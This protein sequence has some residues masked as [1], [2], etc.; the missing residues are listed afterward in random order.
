MYHEND[1]I[2]DISILNQPNQ[3]K[4]LAISNINAEHVFSVINVIQFSYKFQSIL[5]NLDLINL[6]RT[7]LYVPLSN[8][9][10]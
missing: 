6:S 1:R 5:C 7:C 3:M 10:H 8:K 4:L 2:Y 9:L